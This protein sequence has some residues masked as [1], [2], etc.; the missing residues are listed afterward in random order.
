MIQYKNLGGNSNVALYEL[1]DYSITVIFN[2]GSVYLYTNSS[3]GV[4]NI[5]QMKA[6]AQ[7][8]FGLNSF[9]RNYVNNLYERKWN[10]KISA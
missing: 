1:G 8:G 9:I 10:R 4:Y 2:D 7:R 6:L 3:A 5:Q